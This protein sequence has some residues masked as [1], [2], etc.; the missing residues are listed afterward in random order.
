MPL[1]DVEDPAGTHEPRDRPR[2]RAEIGQPPERP[3]P[4]VHDVEGLAGERPGQVVDVGDD[5]PCAIGEPR[6]D[7]ELARERDRGF[8]EIDARDLGGAEARPRQRVE[9]EVA[10]QM[11]ERLP[12]DIADL[13]PL[14]GRDP[15]VVGGIPETSDVVE[16]AGR[17]DRGPRVPELP[18]VGDLAF[19]P[20]HRHHLIRRLI[21]AGRRAR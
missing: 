7:R 14:P 8:A 17:M 4:R 3:S 21:G 1:V 9:P 10:L 18:V 15:H 2:P 13:G 20:A 12:R 5:E 16:R 6:L 19:V 11:Q